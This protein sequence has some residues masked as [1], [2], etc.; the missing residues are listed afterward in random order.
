MTTHEGPSVGSQNRWLLGALVAFAVVG[1][2]AF[3]SGETAKKKSALTTPLSALAEGGDVDAMQVLADI[4]RLRAEGVFSDSAANALAATPAS[5]FLT[6]DP[7]GKM[8]RAVMGDDITT[9]LE[10]SEAEP[11][12]LKEKVITAADATELR[13]LSNYNTAA[14]AELASK[15][16][17]RRSGTP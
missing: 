13:R 5:Q 11:L 2:G 9:L 7:K 1:C 4:E 10:Y 8:T 6:L 12:L 14:A 17:E 16:R 15:L 3:G